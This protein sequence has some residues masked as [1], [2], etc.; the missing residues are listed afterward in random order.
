MN[1]QCIVI[2]SSHFMFS[3]NILFVLIMCMHTYMRVCVW[4]TSGGASH[5]RA[6]VLCLCACVCVNV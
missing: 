1:N 5:F 6:C 2:I 3:S 4:F